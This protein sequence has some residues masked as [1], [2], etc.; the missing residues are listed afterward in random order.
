M[1]TAGEQRHGCRLLVEQQRI[2]RRLRR[3]RCSRGHAA[4]RCPLVSTEGC[5][6]Q[7]GQV[8]RLQAVP[9]S[10]FSAS[11]ANAR[12]LLPCSCRSW[13]GLAAAGAATASAPACVLRARR[14]RA[15]QPGALPLL[16]PHRHVSRGAHRAHRLSCAAGWL[17][18]A[19][20]GWRSEA[21]P[22]L[23]LTAAEHQA[24]GRKPNATKGRAR[25]GPAPLSALRWERWPCLCPAP[26]SPRSTTLP[27]W[28]T[29]RPGT[30]SRATRHTTT[31]WC[32]ASASWW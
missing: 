13:S 27:T 24:M 7:L 29:A 25:S 12:P 22:C 4:R 23:A 30:C 26:S 11:W 19:V 15:R 2:R 3:Q 20:R 9:G 18:G 28:S 5:S 16:K 17:S 21:P 31:A 1:P 8:A 32:R 10:Q 14:G 6:G